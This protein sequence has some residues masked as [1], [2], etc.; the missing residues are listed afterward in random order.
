MGNAKRCL[1]DFRSIIDYSV[2]KPFS[3]PEST[4]GSSLFS[5]LPKTSPGWPMQRQ[6]AEA[7]MSLHERFPRQYLGDMFYG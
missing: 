5:D 2:V 6:N 4:A 3:L 1:S 7:M